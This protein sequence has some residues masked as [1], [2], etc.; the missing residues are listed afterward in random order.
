LF[1][2]TCRGNENNYRPANREE[3]YNLQH[4]SA[5]NAVERIFGI[6]KRRFAILTCPP[7]YDMS[8][9]ARIPPALCAIHNFICIHDADEIHDFES[10]VEDPVPGIFHG[11]LARGPAGAAE[12]QRAD[13]KRDEI[14]QAMWE[15]YQE[16]VHAGQHD[17]TE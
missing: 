14:A 6:L 17:G 12:R 16:L 15:S 7:E 9:Q 2:D 10:V 5:C 1:E 13:T 3:L 8:I 4:A 11:E